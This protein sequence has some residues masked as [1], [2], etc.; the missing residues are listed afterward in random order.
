[1]FGHTIKLN[2]NRQGAS[3]KTYVGGC[4]SLVLKLLILSFVVLKLIKLVHLDNATIGS[5]NTLLNLEDEGD[6]SL[7][8]MSLLIF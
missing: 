5:T 3:H 8:D 7:D 1:M 4:I 2:F 6:K